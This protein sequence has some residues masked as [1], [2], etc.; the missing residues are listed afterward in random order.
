VI[1]LSAHNERMKLHV[2]L[3]W[4]IVIYAVLALVW[5]GLVL[6]GMS[7]NILA[8]CIVL[9]ALVVTTAIATRMLRLNSE[10]DIAPY[11]FGWVIVAI[12][13]DAVFAVPTAGWGMYS[14]WNLWV[15]YIILLAVPF[16]VTALSKK[17]LHN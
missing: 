10:R 1:E 7:G 14:D 2:L 12:A 11:A 6:H 8:R 4:G 16:V 3:G 15:G 13:L 9:A 17:K 5:S